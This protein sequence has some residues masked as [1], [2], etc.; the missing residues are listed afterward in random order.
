MLNITTNRMHGEQKRQNMPA[1]MFE[2]LYS[3]SEPQW[4]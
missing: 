1:D 4:C 3:E 2:K